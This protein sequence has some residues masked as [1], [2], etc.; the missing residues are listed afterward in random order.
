[1]T[2][3]TIRSKYFAAGSNPH[4]GGMVLLYREVSGVV[5]TELHSSVKCDS[6]GFT[7]IWMSILMTAAALVFVSV[8]PGKDAGDPSLKTISNIYRLNKVEDAMR[9]FMAFNG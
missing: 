6:P 9:A 4:S 3:A 5:S 8:L 1:M 7:L 2:D